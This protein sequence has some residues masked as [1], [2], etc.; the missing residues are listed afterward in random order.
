MFCSY[1]FV[2]LID[3]FTWKRAYMYANTKINLNKV[4][5]SNRDVTFIQKI[6]GEVHT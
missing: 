6:T 4:Q 2:L 1:S 5:E 3:H